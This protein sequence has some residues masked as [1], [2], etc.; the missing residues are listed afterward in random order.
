MVFR[1]NELFTSFRTPHYK[2]HV[3]ETP[4]SYRF[5][6]LSDPSSDSLRF[7]LR[8]LYVG[9]FVEY[10]VRNPLVSTTSRTEGIDNDQ[11]STAVHA[12]LF[13]HRS[14][15]DNQF[16]AAVDRHMRGLTMFGT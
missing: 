6:L 4:T 14:L 9:P 7:V 12:M 13:P 10:V 15:T 1:E 11:V 3:F 8:Q 16:R 5:V 2:L